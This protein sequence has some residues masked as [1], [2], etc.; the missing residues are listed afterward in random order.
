M[1]SGSRVLRAATV[2]ASNPTSENRISALA[3]AIPFA[4]TGTGA[5]G[6]TARPLP[7]WKA[8]TNSTAISGSNLISVVTTW[9][10]PA[11]CTPRRLIAATTKI[12]PIASGT[13][14]A[15]PTPIVADAAPPNA[16]AIAAVLVNTETQYIHMM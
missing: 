2:A 8:S 14:Q 11:E 10:S 1:R 15:G 5:S 7:T 3:D 6:S 9:N 16:T 4:V 13:T 12:A